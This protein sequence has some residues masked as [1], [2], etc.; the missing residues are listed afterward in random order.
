MNINKILSTNNQNLDLIAK[1]Q[2][3][4]YNKNTPFPSIVIEN[5]FDENY[6][7]QVLSDFPDLSEL[8]TSQ[9]YMNKK[10]KHPSAYRYVSHY[11]LILNI[12][13]ATGCAASIA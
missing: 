3:K 13:N 11:N 4:T 7:S 2:F 10:K 8:K 9:K 6:L 12:H 1:K 5:F